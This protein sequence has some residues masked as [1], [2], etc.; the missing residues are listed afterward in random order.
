MNKIISFVSRLTENKDK[1]DT[2]SSSS[3]SSNGS[4]ISVNLVNG[5][6]DFL[7]DEEKEADSVRILANAYYDRVPLYSRYT[8]RK[9]YVEENINVYMSLIFKYHN[10]NPTQLNIKTFIDSCLFAGENKKGRKEI[11]TH[12]WLN[13]QY[14]REDIVRA[15]NEYKKNPFPY[16]KIYR[17]HLDSYTT[18]CMKNIIQIMD[19][20]NFDKESET[21]SL[22]IQTFKG[23]RSEPVKVFHYKGVIMVNSID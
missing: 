19:F 6:Q 5:Y 16:T 22:V 20:F 13:H 7:T 15:I 17:H 11:A 23:D 18:E 14:T 12:F 8:D 10:I 4:M 2:Y 3:S 21:I 9:Q 1:V